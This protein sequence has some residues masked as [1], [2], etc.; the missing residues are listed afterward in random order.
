MK[1]PERISY[2]RKIN[3]GFPTGTLEEVIKYLTK[4]HSEAVKDVNNRTYER[5]GCV[6]S[7]ITFREEWYGYED[8]EYTLVLTYEEPL[9]LFNARLAEWNTWNENKKRED[10]KIKA[11]HKIN[12]RMKK[13][14]EL[15]AQLAKL[16]GR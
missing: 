5:D 14:K 10:A 9:E 8:C 16:K 13:I 3:V 11:D 7:S 1:K 2:E 4:A 6:I 12:A 15:E